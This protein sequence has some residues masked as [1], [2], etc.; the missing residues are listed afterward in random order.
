MYIHD[1]RVTIEYL[2]ENG[3]LNDAVYYEEATNARRAIDNA[4][5]KL[6]S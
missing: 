2:T 1:Y 5:T 4:I 3:D 6:L